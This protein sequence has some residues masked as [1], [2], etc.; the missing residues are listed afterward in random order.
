M[1]GGPT[2]PRDHPD[3]VEKEP[4]AASIL[5][6]TYPHLGPAGL[7]TQFWTELY[8]PSVDVHSVDPGEVI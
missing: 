1:V 4:Q 3:A 6:L 7:K 2:L 8:E 5:G